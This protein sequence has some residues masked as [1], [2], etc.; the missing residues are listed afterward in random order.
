MEAGH[1][2]RKI[3]VE[4]GYFKMDIHHL[5]IAEQKVSILFFRGWIPSMGYPWGGLESVFFGFPGVDFK[6]V[7]IED[8]AINLFCLLNAYQSVDD[9]FTH[10]FRIP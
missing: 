6:C 8:D 9:I 3:K 7:R 4:N 10:H 2:L 5:I 1:A